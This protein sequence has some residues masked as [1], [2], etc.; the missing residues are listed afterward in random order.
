MLPS[1]INGSTIIDDDI[2]AIFDIDPAIKTIFEK[3]NLTNNQISLFVKMY[4]NNALE[5]KKNVKS[6]HYNY[7]EWILLQDHI[8]TKLGVYPED[9]M[10]QYISLYDEEA[11]YD[12]NEKTFS[13]MTL[14]F[15]N[16]PLFVYFKALEIGK[17]SP[18]TS[19]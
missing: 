16:E 17:F 10:N 12:K 1:Y 8:Y 7:H 2:S 4:V 9:I 5:N 6:D 15:F 18:Y 13:F 19:I 3:I 14:P 11:L